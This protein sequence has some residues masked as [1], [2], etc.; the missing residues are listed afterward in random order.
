MLGDDRRD[1]GSNPT[2]SYLVCELPRV[3]ISCRHVAHEGLAL[4][5]G[6]DAPCHGLGGA[7]RD[8]GWNDTHGDQSSSMPMRTRTPD[9]VCVGVP[10][11]TM[12]AMPRSSV[13]VMALTGMLRPV[14]E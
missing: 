13:P 3:R 11:V 4:A 9:A 1:G 6:L 12:A 8:K 5:D 10:V 14:L 7:I 2:L